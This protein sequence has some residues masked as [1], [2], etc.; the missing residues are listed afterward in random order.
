MKEVVLLSAVALVPDAFDRVLHWV[1]PSYPLHGLFHSLPFYV[2]LILVLSLTYRKVVVYPAMAAFSASLDFLNVNPQSLMYPLYSPASTAHI[3]FVRGK[4]ESFMGHFP[5][6]LG[7]RLSVGHYLVFELIGLFIFLSIVRRAIRRPVVAAPGD[8]CAEERIYQ[9]FLRIVAPTSPSAG[10]LLNAREL[11]ALREVAIRHNM[12]AL[13]HVRLRNLSG[14]VGGDMEKFLEEGKKYFMKCAAL[15]ARQEDLENRVVSLLRREGLRTVVMRGNAIARDIYNDPNSRTSADI[16]IL[17]RRNDIPRITSTLSDAGYSIDSS[18]PV[19]YCFSHIHHATF[20]SP[21]E[22]IPV[23]IHWLFGV[24]YFF[25]VSSEQIWDEVVCSDD[26]ECRLSPEFKMIMLLVHHHSHSFR[27]LKI[28]VDILWTMHKYDR[29][30]DWHGFALKLKRTGLVKTTNIAMSQIRLLWGETADRLSSIG[31]LDGALEKIDCRV[32]K[33]L[34]AYFAPDISKDYHRQIYRDKLIARLALDKWRTIIH[35]FF[36]TL[37]PAPRA[38]KELY[39]DRR[40]W[41]LPYN[42]S[43]FITWRLAEWRK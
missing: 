37:L 39:G 31:I 16:D 10:F 18:M 1:I 19:E 27:E 33:A 24:P 23:E 30:I 35:S 7:Y 3:P 34:E 40:N 20:Y 13:M 5:H 29:E 12:L 11:T 2:A 4:I 28:L 41:M 43:R 9:L 38:I 8:R 42:Y 26:G 36:L 17:V 6:T 32:P 21:E 22:N 15:S 14:N 25:N